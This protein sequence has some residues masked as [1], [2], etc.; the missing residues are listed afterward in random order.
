SEHEGE[1]GLWGLTE[2]SQAAAISL[3]RHNGKICHK[4]PE[5]W[6]EAMHEAWLA[7]IFED[8]GRGGASLTRE[9]KE[10]I[11][12]DRARHRDENGL[13]VIDLSDFSSIHD[14]GDLDEWFNFGAF[15][16]LL[17]GVKEMSAGLA[18][19]ITDNLYKSLARYS[20]RGLEEIDSAFVENFICMGKGNVILPEK[21]VDISDTLRTLDLK[22]ASKILGLNDWLYPSQYFNGFER[23]TPAA[24]KFLADSKDIDDLD[25]DVLKEISP[26]A[27]EALSHHGQGPVGGLT[28]IILSLGGLKSLDEETAKNLSNF[29]PSGNVSKAELRLDGIEDLDAKVASHLAKVRAQDGRTVLSLDGIK[30]LSLPT[31]KAL[32]KFKGNIGHNSR[33]SKHWSEE[34]GGV[35]SLDGVKSLDASLAGHLAKVHYANISLCGL[36]SIDAE[37]AEALAKYKPYKT[38]VR[39]SITLDGLSTLSVEVVENLQD[40]QGDFISLKGLQQIDE[41]TAALL[42]SFKDPKGASGADE[43]IAEVY[44]KVYLDKVVKEVAPEVACKLFSHFS[45]MEIELDDLSVEMAK[46]LAANYKSEHKQLTIKSL[47]QCDTEALKALIK[48]DGKLELPEIEELDDETAQVFSDSKNVKLSGLK[49]LSKEGARSLLK[50]GV[51]SSWQCDLMKMVLGTDV[52]ALSEVSA[53]IAKL[54]AKS[55]ERISLPLVTS[56]SVEAAEELANVSGQYLE[57]DGLTDINQEVAKHLAGFQNEAS[58]GSIKKLSLNG[59]TK[60]DP[61]VA[62]AFSKYKHKLFLNGVDEIPMEVAEALLQNAKEN[63]SEYYFKGL[64]GR[65]MEASVAKLI[66]PLAYNTQFFTNLEIESLA[67]GYSDE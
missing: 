42:T 52:E 41:K 59:L 57:L 27:A 58:R 16:I 48:F 7:R 43:E 34:G 51:S 10:K 1:L 67:A 66:L 26:E 31:A 53:D 22:K 45:D 12:F 23:I 15:N 39:Q 32:S 28:S 63:G 21:F 60:I 30:S 49:S 47:S 20:F 17:D 64:D 5:E 18:R 8:C 55:G 38:G 25:L 2:L 44:P 6:A 35:L 36:K 19:V 14:D 37:T 40:Y 65:K 13:S 24:A 4:D 29:S 56:L 33:S 54:L 62:R 3:S 46:E 61:V 9:I 11:E 50:G